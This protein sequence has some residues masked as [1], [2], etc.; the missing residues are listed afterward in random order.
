MSNARSNSPSLPLLIAVLLLVA[1][2]SRA[3]T[4]AL[5]KVKKAMGKLEMAI[6][7]KEETKADEDGK[8]PPLKTESWTFDCGAAKP[9]IKYG[10]FLNSP[11]HYDGN[12]PALIN[13]DMGIGLDGDAFGNWY[14]GNCI[15]ILL[16]RKDVIAQQ[17]ASKIESR[18]DQRGYL[19][20]TWELDD[21]NQLQLAFVVPDDGH[22]I[23]ARV[24]LQGPTAAKA[25]DD[26][27]DL[28]MTCYPGG[29]GPAY[30]LP[31]HRWVQTA[32]ARNE[33]PHDHAGNEFPSVPVTAGE[34]WVFYAD[35]LARSGSL[36]L[37][38]IPS[39]K[40]TGEVKM[41]SYGQNTTLHHPPQTTSCR[42]AFF[43]YEL[44]M[45]DAW[46]TFSKIAGKE[47]ATLKTMRFWTEEK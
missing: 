9:C 16:D 18:S 24:D 2:E 10:R 31:S 32:K 1:A 4:S 23:Y 37:V 15:R 40:L 25:F 22:A 36:G 41:S 39:E 17:T 30:N 29:F 34:S 3:E 7:H 8:K 12:H 6:A 26:S 19:R 21:G 33:V 47:L 43:A 44:D 11:P 46:E 20:F 5:D 27:L 28:Q 38:F 45:D 14:R 35:K 13:S 42:M